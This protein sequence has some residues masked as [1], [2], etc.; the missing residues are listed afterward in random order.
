LEDHENL[1][2]LRERAR[3]EL[4]RLP[5][6]IVSVIL[7]KKIVREEYLESILLIVSKTPILTN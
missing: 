5:V 7:G 2:I 4:K 6:L 1:S 3:L